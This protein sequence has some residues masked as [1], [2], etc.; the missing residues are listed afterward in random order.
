[1][2][3][4]GMAGIFTVHIS[5]ALVLSTDCRDPLS[6][7]SVHITHV[8]FQASPCQG[9]PQLYLLH[10]PLGEV[11]LPSSGPCYPQLWVSDESQEAGHCGPERDVSPA[12]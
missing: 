2:G 12:A 6:G 9:D 7:P 3:T 11:T 10:L 8:S 5:K 1:M 4:K